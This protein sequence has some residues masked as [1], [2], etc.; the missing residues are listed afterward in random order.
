MLAHTEN[1]F[2][3]TTINAHY[4]DEER[5]L[6]HELFTHHYDELIGISRRLR[7]RY[8]TSETLNT[9]ALIHEAFLRLRPDRDF[10]NT[11]HFFSAVALAMRHTLIDHA[12]RKQHAADPKAIGEPIDEIPEYGFS[13]LNVED[14][15]A[16]HQGL[17][18]VA[19]QDPRL[20]RMIDCRFFLGLTLEETAF[21][22]AVTE[23]T[24]R[25]DWT[26]ARALLRH[27]LSGEAERSP[28]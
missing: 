23:R 14:V 7:R 20:I 18:F 13:D 11:T 10:S 8:N 25:R 2:D 17:E 28:G 22:Q 19:A 21:A 27:Y 24:V 12:R 16:V 9:S 4:K 6:A 1:C 5:K 15:L 3:E 26:K